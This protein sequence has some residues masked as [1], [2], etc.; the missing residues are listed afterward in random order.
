MTTCTICNSPTAEPP[1]TMTVDGRTLALCL[2]CSEWGYLRAA[3]NLTGQRAADRIEGARNA[4]KWAREHAVTV[5][6]WKR[7]WEA[8]P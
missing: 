4:G 3:E 8:R 2:T 7:Q 5:A 6:R 1:A